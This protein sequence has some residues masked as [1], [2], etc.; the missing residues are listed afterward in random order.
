MLRPAGPRSCWGVRRTPLTCKRPCRQHVHACARPGTSAMM[1]AC[2]C[3]ALSLHPPCL[4]MPRHLDT[5]VFTPRNLPT[6]QSSSSCRVPAPPPPPLRPACVHTP[7]H[8][9][10]AVTHPTPP[11]THCCAALC[12]PS[13]HTPHTHMYAGVCARWPVWVPGTLPACS[14]VWRVPVSMASTTALRST[15]RWE[16]GTRGVWLAPSCIGLSSC[17]DLHT[18]TSFCAER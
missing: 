3:A 8:L 2:A 11:P 14:G 9:G 17:R 13:P 4:C 1:C 5:P 6:H 7:P 10:L 16:K 12:P 18:P 15:R